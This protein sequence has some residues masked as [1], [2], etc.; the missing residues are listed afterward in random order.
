MFIYTALGDSITAGLA[1]TSP[2]RA[3]P[4]LVVSMM[5]R[6]VR[7]QGMRNEVLAQPGWTSQALTTAVFDNPAA[8]L[9]ASQAVTIWV[10]G[11]N[12]VRTGLAVLGGAPKSSVERSIVQYGKDLGALAM[13]I[14][15]VSHG[16]IIICTQYN[17]FP[18][19]PLAVRAIGALNDAT[20]A[21]QSRVD[22]LVAR[23]DI[24]FAGRESQLI[25]GF[26]TGRIEDA[27][28]GDPAVHPNNAGHQVIADN[29][30]PLVH[31]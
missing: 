8:I 15:H 14:H 5:Q 3:Y 24:W 10:G 19:S 7:G 4:A 31:A 25:A 21:V 28:K 2:A 22:A 18:A 11:D 13:Y 12:L 6:T 30:L 27:L 16:R 23:P 29:L 26:R 20:L 17:P 1:A 9:A